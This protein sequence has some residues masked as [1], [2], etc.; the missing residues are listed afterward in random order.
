MIKK[1][2]NN[3]ALHNLISLENF[4]FIL[5]I[6]CFKERNAKRCFPDLFQS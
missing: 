3:I 1:H 5:R 2:S 6:D 4:A